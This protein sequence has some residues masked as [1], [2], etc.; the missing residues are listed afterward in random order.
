M[1]RQTVK[2]EA[3]VDPALGTA[4]A[5]QGSALVGESFAVYVG[6]IAVTA[7]HQHHA[8]QLVIS[9]GPSLT[10]RHAGGSLRARCALIDSEA[11]HAI[12]APA[13]KATLIYLEPESAWGDAVLSM[14]PAGVQ[15]P[16]VWPL[17]GSPLADAMSAWVS[18]SD[19]CVS[20][21][22]GLL[23]WLRSRAPAGGRPPLPGSLARMLDLMPA[24]T[25]GPIRIKELAT[26]VCLSPDRLS[27][28]VRQHM[29]TTVRAYVRWQ[30]LQAAAR[31][32]A[33]GAGIT[34]AAHAAG[35]SDASHMNRVFRRSLGI[36]PSAVARAVRWHVVP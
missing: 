17:D 11:R 16:G 8:V 15:M 5:W 26:A 36:S 19:S 7:V 24:L 34:E 4:F 13:H 12:A 14:R 2:S 21:L 30:R 3:G 1:R 22:E 31:C 25:S 9:D 29:G 20:Q 18:S 28:L 23:Q 35:F 27:H 32:L 33:K 6:P 10:W